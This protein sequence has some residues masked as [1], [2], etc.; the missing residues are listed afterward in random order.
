MVK[1]TIVITILFYYIMNIEYTIQYTEV[2]LIAKE[3]YT[4]Q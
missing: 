2:M 1:I 4:Q 3:L